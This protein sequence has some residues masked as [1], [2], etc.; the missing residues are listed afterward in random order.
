MKSRT[1]PP[2][3]IL[4]SKGG[5]YRRNGRFVVGGRLS[6]C[7]ETLVMA[8]ACDVQGP[9][10]IRREDGPWYPIEMTIEQAEQALNPNGNFFGERRVRRARNFRVRNANQ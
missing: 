10:E 6:F 4:P 2:F 9:H 1:R 8:I 7:W 3:L 5:V